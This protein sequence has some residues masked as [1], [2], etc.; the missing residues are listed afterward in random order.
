M[1]HVVRDMPRFSRW[2]L[3]GALS[4]AHGCAPSQ[5]SRGQAPPGAAPTMAEHMKDHFTQALQARDALVRGDLAAMKRSAA[6]LADHRL[7]ETLPTAWRAEVRDMQNAAGLARQASD[8]AVA[9]DAVGAMGAACGECHRAF[10]RT[11]QLA[12]P[13]R[14]AEGT[15]LAD[16]MM[17]HRWAE[18]RMWEGLVGP[19]DVAWSAGIAALKDSPLHPDMLTPDRSP[20]PEI[21]TLVHRVHTVAVRGPL[22]RGSQTRAR[23]YGEY[24]AT[25]E[26]CHAELGVRVPSQF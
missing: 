18:A 16:A 2:I 17:R 11:A 20:P 21:M 24:L 6:W 22:A 23:L 12:R 15:S 9:A 8:I 14:K 4:V 26:A 25:C 1:A 10:G 13:S 7:G 5:H 3:L 19:S